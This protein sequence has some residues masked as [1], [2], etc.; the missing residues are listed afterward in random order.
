MKILIVG[1]S[2]VGDMVMAQTLF[3]E[4]KRRYPKSVIDVLAPNWSHPILERMP[5]V[6]NAI[7]MPVGHGALELGKRWKLGQKL[8]EVTYDQAIVLPNSLKSALIPCF[9]G[10][11]K[12]TGWR[13][14]MRYGLINDI[15]LLDKSRY[16]LMVERFVALGVAPNAELPSPIAPPHLRVEPENVRSALNSFQLQ[17]EMPVLA[18]CPGAEFGE[19]KRWPADYYAAVAQHQ[20]QQGWQVWIFGSAND[21]RIAEQIRS[22]LSLQDQTHCHNLAGSTSLADAVDLMSLAKA[23]TTNDSGLMHIAAALD[24]PLVVLY[25][26]SSP[27][28][29]PPLNQQVKI[30]RTGI[31][32]SPCFK[33]ECPLGHLKCLKDL[34]KDQVIESL[35]QLT[36]VNSDA[37]G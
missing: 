33:R 15:R 9:A 2:W 25:G 18:L 16:P 6:N 37:T 34:S 29:T 14:E 27:D 26:S 31:A 5:E 22:Q 32:C 19:A 12:R 17:T 10:I 4:L 30:L 3:I 24:R 23:V 36:Q 7:M 28:F 20:I 21:H 13:G 35:E 8:K 1:P 11:E